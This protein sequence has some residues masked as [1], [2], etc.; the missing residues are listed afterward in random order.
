MSI[1][2]LNQLEDKIQSAVE[3]IG[4]YRLEMEELREAKS[5]LEQENNS[6]RS[7]LQ[8]WSEKVSSLLGRLDTVGEDV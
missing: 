2:S 7:E 1:E 4:I 5:R 3:T 6:L 8:N